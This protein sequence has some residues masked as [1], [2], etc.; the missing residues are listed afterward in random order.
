MTFK[1]YH[2]QKQICEYIKLQYPNVYFYSDSVAAVKLTMGQAVRNK[3]IQNSNFKAPDIMVIQPSKHFH[4]LFME[5]KIESPYKKNG[6]LYADEHLR[7]QAETIEKLKKL[8]YCADFIWSF[9]MAKSFI[10][11]YM[12]YV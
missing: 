1:E 10:D 4:G 2:L 5:L 8:G 6:E 9:D 12:K 11:N 7:G 3:A